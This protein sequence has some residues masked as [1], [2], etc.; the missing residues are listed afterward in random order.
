MLVCGLRSLIAGVALLPFLFRSKL[1]FS[2]GM[3]VY[4][5][6][7]ASLCLSIVL[8]LRQTSAVIAIGMQYG[9]VVWLFLAASILNKSVNKS[10]ILPVVL[11]TTGVII[12]MLSGIAGSNMKGNLIALT[13]SI[14][15]AVM[16]VAAK[17]VSSG[18]AGN[19]LGLVSL[20]NLFTGIFAF[21][22]PQFADIL[23]LNG[24]EW[25]L[26]LILGIVQVAL[27]YAMYNLG[28]NL[29]SPQKASVI[30]MW[31]MILGPVWTALFLK[32]YPSTMVIIG[33]VIIIA[34][35]FL[36]SKAAPDAAAGDGRL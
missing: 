34:G 10:R 19:A 22:P 13:E 4:L 1:R 12:F 18:E 26:M 29:I 20:A 23:T 16:T 30:A 21:F 36:D 15:F 8:A 14:F 32:E 27:G 28:V 31:E 6:A 24:S 35:I 3:L 17:K 9:S 5:V 25:M 33:F 7:Y 2:K 11:T